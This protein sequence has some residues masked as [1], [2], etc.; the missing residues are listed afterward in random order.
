M[1]TETQT[2]AQATQ[3]RLLNAASTVFAEHGFKNASIR[4]I[5]RR[6]QA[7]VAAVHYHF[8]DKEQLYA[9]V[10]RQQYSQTQDRFPYREAADQT[11]PAAERLRAFV[12]A[13]ISRLLDVGQRSELAKL[14]AREMLDQSPVL[15]QVVQHLIRPQ[16]QLLSGIV[17]ELLGP[18]APQDRV[19]LCTRSILGQCVFYLHARPV[20]DRLY[21]DFKQHT[22]AADVLAEHVYRFSL[23]GLQQTGQEGRV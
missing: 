16:Q 17:R 20:I 21:P 15:D 1:T 13:F 7:N 3:L 9:E 2:E 8:G 23:A 10:L 4:E 18:A 14:V 6:A 5:C 12:H 11:R 19:D 22:P